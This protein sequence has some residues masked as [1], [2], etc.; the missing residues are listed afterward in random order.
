M[1]PAALDIAAG[2]SH[3][4][5]I[6]AAG[7]VRCWGDNTAG[8]LGIGTLAGFFPFPVA[9][10]LGGP[11]T[12]LEAGSDHTCAVTSDGGAKCWGLNS[13]GQLGDGTTVDWGVP[14]GVSG[15]STGV[16]DV[17]AGEDHSCAL[18][19]AG[20]VKCWG[21]NY[22]GQLGD[23]TFDASLVP[24]DVLELGDVVQVAVGDASTCALDAAG[25]VTCWGA[26]Y[27]GFFEVGAVE[28]A[29]A[30]AMGELHACA[31][32]TTH[33]VKCWGRNGLGAL[34]DGTGMDSVF[35]PVDVVGLTTGV[36]SVYAGGNSSCAI[37]ESGA[38]R[39]WGDNGQGQLGNGEAGYAVTPQVVVG[40][41]FVEQIFADGFE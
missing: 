21:E 27:A 16:R 41:P 18:L 15:L 31:L 6:T 17:A 36:A 39:C 40:S 24:V 9:P 22:A 7:E 14:V 5:A 28:G 25:V 34:G 11:A 23:G 20:N 1:E 8:K 32:T 3:S 13:R 38:A 37:T 30:I 26:D 10:D 29:T 12:R 35:D 2:D 4:C 33:G 19:D